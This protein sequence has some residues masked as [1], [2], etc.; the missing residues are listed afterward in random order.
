MGPPLVPKN[1]KQCASDDCHKWV[2]ASD[3]HNLCISHRLS[4]DGCGGTVD[5]PCFVCLDWT[6]SQWDKFNSRRRYKKKGPRSSSA[7]SSCLEEEEDGQL[8][9]VSGEHVPLPTLVGQLFPLSPPGAA[10]AASPARESVVSSSADSPARDVSRPVLLVQHAV[11]T[12][13]AERNQATIAG[14]AAQVSQLSSLFMQSL[15]QPQMNPWQMPQALQQPSFLQPQLPGFTETWLA[16]Q[17]LHAGFPQPPLPTR[18]VG[19]RP[20]DRMGSVAPATTSLLPAASV[21]GGGVR[22]L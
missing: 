14:L 9:P 19:Q 12:P 22:G 5:A 10:A 7:G 4:V 11:S 21:G 17:N 16:Q 20:L 15:A 13:S 2:D 18:M 6:P 8:D 1:V 3:P